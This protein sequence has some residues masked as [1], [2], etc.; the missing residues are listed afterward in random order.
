MKKI[1]FLG[2]APIFILL[3]T[4]LAGCGGKKNIAFPPGVSNDVYVLSLGADTSHLNGDQVSWLQYNLNWMDKNMTRAFKS[5]GLN[6][7]RVTDEKQFSEGGHLLKFS[8]TKHRMIPKGARH[9]LGMSAGTDLLSVH[10]ELLD[11]DRKV[12][13]S[14]DDTQLSTRGGTYCAQTLNRNTVG[15]IDAFLRGKDFL[16][17]S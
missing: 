4:L 9:W 2:L 14:W 10:Y 16:S 11:A 1:V 17:K 8:I 7:L 5:K 3:I 13:L 6:I 15:K 12:V